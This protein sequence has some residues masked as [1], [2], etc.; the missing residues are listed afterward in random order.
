MAEFDPSD[1]A[2]APGFNNWGYAGVP[3]ENAVYDFLSDTKRELDP[4]FETINLTFELVNTFL[5]FISSLLIDF[6]NPLKAILDEI[7][8]LLENFVSD[9][10]NAGFY[11]TWDK[12]AFTSEVVEK[13]LGGY[14]AYEQR[15]IKKL[16]NTSD[17]TRPDFS[18]DS[19][20]FALNFFAGADATSIKNI[21]NALS[22]L[23]KLFTTGQPDEAPQAPINLSSAFYN[24]I[25]GE[26]KLPSTYKPDG[27]KVK[28]KLPPPSSKRPSF[29]VSF[30][31][32][33]YFLISVATRNAG[34][35]ISYIN[36]VSRSPQDPKFKASPKKS[37]P[38][39]VN[40]SFADARLWNVLSDNLT[41]KLDEKKEYKPLPTP[42]D[43]LKGDNDRAW[44]L[45][46]GEDIYF[47]KIDKQP[48]SDVY[49]LF[50][51]QSG[52]DSI[53]GDNDFSFKIP[54]EFI[55]NFK[56]ELNDEYHISVFSL[57]TSDIADV[58]T[59]KK[60]I[61][62]IFRTGLHA[63]IKKGVM[64]E[65]ASKGQE[66]TFEMKKTDKVSSLSLPSDIV[67]LKTPSDLRSK[68]MKA[69]RF[70]FLGF[71]LGVHYTSEFTSEETEFITRLSK[72]GDGLGS[73]YKPNERTFEFSRKGY[74]FD[75]SFPLKNKVLT[76]QEYA[77]ELLEWVDDIMSNIVH[78][79]PSTSVLISIK[80]TLDKIDRYP[81]DLYDL[82]SQT[83]KGFDV[84]LYAKVEYVPNRP[85]TIT[86]PGSKY[87]SEITLKGKLNNPGE[88]P[89]NTFIFNL[90][91]TNYGVFHIDDFYGSLIFAKDAVPL[92]NEAKKVL[93]LSAKS[94][95][96]GEWSNIRP[97]RDSD[98]SSITGFIDL[99]K[100]FL[101]AVS[102]GMEGIVA[103]ILKY[104]H[105]LKTRIAQL[106]A[107]ILKIKSFI[108]LILS[109]R[110][111]AGLYV[112]FHLADGTSG[113]VNAVNQSEN[114]PDIGGE[115]YGLGAMLVA[116][117]LPSLVIDFFI[118]LC[119]GE[120]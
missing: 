94:E 83:A 68:Y 44:I 81:Y 104:I 27:I 69:V 63:Q 91:S 21:I 8:S 37:S 12:F 55:R 90:F 78:L 54:L 106:Q 79:I 33:D 105:L 51:Y 111:P 28:W 29:P 77:K 108:D 57:N 117:G 35:R 80:S 107:I 48:I 62:G 84:G 24:D 36:N 87:N 9:L 32:P 50:I 99:V 92:F 18:S 118:A 5:D 112:N 10:R 41:I 43:E 101:E 86:W 46:N 45:S 71:A 100:Q 38:Q 56:G 76:N 89:S 115:G 4:V 110:F 22:K 14:Q 19:K 30:I 6:T 11:F 102:K 7:I 20:V 64:I 53:I 113:L 70:F 65:D 114:K 98:L 61:T 58:V 96:E 116:G 47:N 103:Q 34:D 60:D 72:S 23:I 119:G 39:I 88:Y 13:S 52:G 85:S 2:K 95:E 82:V 31:T 73:L 74:L 120:D 17:R 49:K 25:V 75:F 109:F 66:K 26:I 3:K 42:P 16:L 59:E 15:V 93:M 40:G 97:F 1:A 67:T